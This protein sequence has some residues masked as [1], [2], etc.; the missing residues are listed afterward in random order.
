MSYSTKYALHNANLKAILNDMIYKINNRVFTTGAALAIGDTAKTAVANGAF[1]VM[2]N[3]V[4]SSI[5]ADTTGT[6]FTAT[7]HDIADG[8]GA[9]YLFYL[10]EDND[11]KIEMGT[12]TLAGTDAVCPDTPEGGLKVGEVK[13]VT[14]GAA[15]DA[16]TTALDAE[17]VTDTYT[18][19]SD[20]LEEVL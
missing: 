11:M 8:Y 17:T 15:F 16:T 4:I 10:N 18:S 6:P 5:S 13:I 2:R 9:I 20:V 7:T 1:T 3:G 19:V 14:V 12:A